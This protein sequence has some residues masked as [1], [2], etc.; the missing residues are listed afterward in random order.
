MIYILLAL[1]VALALVSGFEL[2]IIKCLGADYR[3]EVS[4]LKYEKLVLER[5]VADLKQRLNKMGNVKEGLE[6]D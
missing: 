3:A 5:K 1:V 6:N 4:V 2:A